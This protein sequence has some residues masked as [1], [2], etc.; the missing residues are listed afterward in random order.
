M[1]PND[2]LIC[3]KGEDKTEEVKAY[4]DVGREIGDYIL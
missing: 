1:N 3:L 2:Y 4:K